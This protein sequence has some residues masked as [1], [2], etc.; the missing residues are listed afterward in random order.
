VTIV[1]RN[2][3]GIF[4]VIIVERWNTRIGI[5][6]HYMFMVGY[7]MVSEVVVVL[8]MLLLCC[9]CCWSSS[10]SAGTRG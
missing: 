5:P 3:A 9:C 1:L 4:D 2:I 8:V 7:N 6:D 10:S